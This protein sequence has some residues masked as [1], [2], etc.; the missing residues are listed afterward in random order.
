[1]HRVYF[2]QVHILYYIHLISLFSLSSNS[3]WCVSFC[4]LYTH[5]HTHTHTHTEYPFL[6]PTPFCWTLQDR[7]PFTLISC[8]HYHHHHIIIRY[9][10]HKWM[11]TWDVW[12][13]ELG[14]SRFSQWSPELLMWS[15]MT[16]VAHSKGS[17]LCICKPEK[18]FQLWVSP[19]QYLL[20]MF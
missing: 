13:F 9:R 2:E 10:F 14:L 17:W 8:H 11:K 15:Y 18:L 5:T 7:H 12:L 3:V 4:Y 1:M 19:S 6:S 16:S 20:L